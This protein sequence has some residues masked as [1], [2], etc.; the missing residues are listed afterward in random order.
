MKLKQLAFSLM[1]IACG[2]TATAV[3]VKVTMNNVSPTM[4]L[5]VKDS[6]TKVETGEPENK[7]YT[8]DAP[9][10]EYVLTVYATDGATVNGT[11]VINVTDAAEEQSF[12]VLTN[13]AGV[14]N[15]HD[16]NT[17][18]TIENGDYTIDVSISS[19]EGELQLI[20][21]GKSLTENRYTFLALSGHTYNVKFIPSEEHQKEDYTILR[22][23]GTLTYN[24]NLIGEIPKCMDYSIKI[25]RAHV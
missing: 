21:L 7:I 18:W 24:V 5:T 16:D 22:K 6:N 25:G 19:R 12:D 10:G 8:F 17:I 20:T 9:A 2:V 1:A 23:S 3:P 11:I 4:S 15:K 13:T 14:T